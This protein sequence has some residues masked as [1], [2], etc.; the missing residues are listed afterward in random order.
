MNHFY[1]KGCAEALLGT[2]KYVKCA[3]CSEIYGDYI[4]EMPAGQMTWQ[5]YAPG[6][7]P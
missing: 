5:Y 2:K 7:V 3:V 6:L 4:G 1:H